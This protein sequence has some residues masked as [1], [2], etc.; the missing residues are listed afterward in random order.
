MRFFLQE[1]NACQVLVIKVNNPEALLLHISNLFSNNDFLEV[2][3]GV[4]HLNVLLIEHFIGIEIKVLH[5]P[6]HVWVFI[7]NLRD[8]FL[9]GIMEV[10]KAGFHVVRLSFRGKWREIWVAQELLEVAELIFLDL[11]GVYIVLIL[12]G[13]EVLLVV[14]LK[15]WEDSLDLW[16]LQH[17]W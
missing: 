13:E 17:L 12:L 11:A 4:L 1:E 3:H 14:S 5:T 16:L 10:S 2:D 15:E 6:S 7:N 9:L 8:H